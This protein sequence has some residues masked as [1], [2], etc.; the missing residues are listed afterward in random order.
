MRNGDVFFEVVGNEVA[1]GFGE[2]AAAGGVRPQQVAEEFNLEREVEQVVLQTKAA[3]AIGAFLAVRVDAGLGRLSHPGGLQAFGN[4]GVR[5]ADY[6]GFVEIVYNLAVDAVALDG[7]GLEVALFLHEGAHDVSHVVL[8]RFHGEEGGEEVRLGESGFF[9]DEGPKEFQ[10][11]SC[12]PADGEGG[13]HS[14]SGEVG[15]VEGL[16][17]GFGQRALGDE[18]EDGPGRDAALEQVAHALYPGGGFAGHSRP[19]EEDFGV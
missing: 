13:D 18:E 5:E 17:I 19:V 4:F 9:G 8:G 3:E 6:G 14:P 12:Q 10:R 16:T 7:D 2:E 1:V 15:V 11:A